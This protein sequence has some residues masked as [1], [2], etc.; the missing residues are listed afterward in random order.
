MKGA[1]LSK[2]ITKSSS[3]EP[4]GSG[5]PEGCDRV[6]MTTSTARTLFAQHLSQ[7]SRQSQ[8]HPLYTQEAQGNLNWEGSC[9]RAL[10]TP[11]LMAPLALSSSEP[12]PSRPPEG[13]HLRLCAAV[14]WHSLVR[15]LATRFGG[16]FAH[17]ALTLSH[18]LGQQEKGAEENF[19][20]HKS[21]WG[22]AAWGV[23]H[24]LLGTV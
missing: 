17:S 7:Y 18:S 6:A 19:Q 8:C 13:L 1:P 22:W 5:A 4:L 12:W 3:E 14:T 20:S 2:A 23:G 24:H 16:A 10:S 9:T 21:V 15:L 11:R